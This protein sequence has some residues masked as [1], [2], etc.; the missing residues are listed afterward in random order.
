MTTD[1]A[2]WLLLTLV[3]LDA[4]FDILVV[5]QL[6]R[7][8]DWLEKVKL[9]KVQEATMAVVPIPP[10]MPAE[11]VQEVLVVFEALTGLK[12][13]PDFG[14]LQFVDKKVD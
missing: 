6:K 7:K 13:V 12:V 8:I 14:G 4:Y 1:W 3:G 9:Y 5:T 11:K 2:Y 10:S